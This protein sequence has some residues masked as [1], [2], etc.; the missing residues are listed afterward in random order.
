[1]VDTNTLVFTPGYTLHEASTR[2]KQAYHD[3]ANYIGLQQQRIKLI[4]RPLRP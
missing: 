3:H 2:G 1:M 4:E